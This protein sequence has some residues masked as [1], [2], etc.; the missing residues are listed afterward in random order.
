VIRF[1]L[2]CDQAHEFE[3]WFGSNSDFDS[4]K[5]RGLVNCPVCGSTHVEKSLMA[6]AVARSDKGKPAPVAPVPG[7][8]PTAPVAMDPARA[9]MMAAIREMVRQVRT[10]AEDVG[11]RFP[12][13]ARKIHYGE[14]KERGII[15]KANPEEARKLL[16]EGISVMPLPNLPED[17]N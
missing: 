17:M 4:Q 7:E 6:P 14:A 5:Q 15:G 9:E 16:E 3:I 8:P 10:S 11:D 2:H 1:S 12:T 13:E